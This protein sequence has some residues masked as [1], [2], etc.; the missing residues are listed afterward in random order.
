MASF[1]EEMKKPKL[2]ELLETSIQL[3]EEL[4]AETQPTGSKPIQEKVRKA[5][6]LLEKASDMLSQ[7]DLFSRNEDWEEIAS[8]DLKYLMLPALKGAL[9]L[10][11]VGTSNRLDVLQDAREH[12]MN[13]LTQS[14]NYHVA[15][16]QLPWAQSSSPEG[17]PAATS[18]TLEPNLVAMA[19]Q[20]QTKIQS[21]AQAQVFGAGYPSLAT[22]TVN[23]WYEQRQKSEV[24]PSVQEAE[25]RAPP[26][27]THTVSEQEEPDLEQKEDEDENALHRMQEWDD[28][29]D[30]HPRGYGNRQNM[31]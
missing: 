9:T 29:K 4:E 7:L 11:L 21:V 22:M 17:N 28:W 14:H 26:P 3:L 15:E 19:S 6:N 23:D 30:T 12:F 18:D 5:L 1:M 10:K 8:A 20:R 16:F 2:R 25:K 27:E 31:G 13:F 24:S